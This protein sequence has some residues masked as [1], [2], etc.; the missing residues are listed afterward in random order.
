MNKLST[1]LA[2]TLAVPATA[3]ASDFT[4]PTGFNF[5]SAPAPGPVAG[6]LDDGT[7]FLSTGSFGADELSVVH[8]DGSSTL[9]ATGFGSLAGIARS[10]VTGDIVVGD[11]FFAPALRVLRDLNN[12]G[13]ALDA[14]EDTAHPVQPGTLPNGLAPLPFALSFKPGTDE[15]YMTGSTPFDPMAASQGAV[16]RIVGGS[17][18]QFALG[19]G[20]AAGMAWDGD[21]LYVADLDSTTFVGR[22][23]TLNDADNDGDA[24]GPGES[25]EFASALSGASGLVRTQDGTFYLSGLSDTLGDFS[26]CIGQLLPDLDDDGV[27]DGYVE[28]YFDGFAFAGALDLIEGA[29]GFVPGV[30]G[31]GRLFVGDFTFTGNRVI[32]SAP[33]ATTTVVG[34]VADNSTFHVNVSGTPGAAAFDILSLDTA[35]ATIPGIGD[36]CTGFGGAYLISPP[37]IIPASGQIAHRVIVKDQPALVGLEIVMQGVVFEGGEYG[38]GNALEFVIA[39]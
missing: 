39:P 8:P 21:D 15:L 16:L 6:I 26:G 14:G 18:T 5:E 22:V 1:L 27:T 13:D 25:A 2:V 37:Q 9:F 12:D 19:L 30:A 33:N 36:L 11:S 7:I 10:P 23:L 28:A 32:R 38:I 3:L 34:T 20:F 24:M 31:Q 4:V 17:Q 35:G 29:G